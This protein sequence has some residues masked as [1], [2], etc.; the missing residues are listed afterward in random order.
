MVMGRMQNTLITMVMAGIERNYPAL[1]NNDNKQ[2][3]L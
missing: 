1:G 3:V 2:R